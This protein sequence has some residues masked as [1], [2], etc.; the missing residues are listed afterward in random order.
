MDLLAKCKATAQTAIGLMKQ[1]GLTGWRFEFNRARRRAG[2]CHYPNVARPGRI[3]LSVHFVDRNS[4]A[5][6]R[7][8]ILH[9]I[10]HA[11]AG[12]LAGHGPAWQ[13]ICLRIGARPERCY[14]EHIDMPKGR[15]Q[16][17]C[18]NC[19]RDHHRHK[20]PRSLTGYHCRK[21]GPQRGQ[22]VWKPVD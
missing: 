5:E 20:R 17:R 6:I 7:D 8:T 9:E 13:A 19:Q 12:P 11:L 10:A 16:A 22:I 14:G 15:W 21:C 18:P 4:E 3:G 2:V 1:F